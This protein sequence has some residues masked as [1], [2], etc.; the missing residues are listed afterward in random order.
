MDVK[1]SGDGTTKACQ[2]NSVVQPL[3]ILRECEEQGV[4]SQ[5]PRV[6]LQTWA[7]ENMTGIRMELKR[8]LH[9]Q[10]LMGYSAEI[11]SL[12]SSQVAVAFLC[13][14]DPKNVSSS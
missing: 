6:S 4:Y 3:K 14:K 7:E 2:S 1:K 10:T 8:L 5:G 12:E 13:S 9:S 11:E